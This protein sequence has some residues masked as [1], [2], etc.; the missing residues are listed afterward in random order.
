[1]SLLTWLQ[2]FNLKKTGIKIFSAASHMGKN[3]AILEKPRIWCI[4]VITAECELEFLLL[5]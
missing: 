2:K 3:R 5:P 1:M 4:L